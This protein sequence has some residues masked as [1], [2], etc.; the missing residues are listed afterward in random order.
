MPRL[1]VLA[2][3][4]SVAVGCD[5]APLETLPMRVEVVSPD[6]GVA[7]TAETVDLALRVR[8]AMAE[9]HVRVG[10][11]EAAFAEARGVFEATVAL[12]PGLNTL[13]V[14][15]ADGE[16]VVARDTLYA[17]RLDVRSV[18]ASGV[19]PLPL[20]SGAA[21]TLLPGPV[22][23]L[24]GGIGTGGPS[25]AL[26]R[27]G[28]GGIVESGL[29]GTARA[30]H[31]ASVLPSGEV[32]ILGGATALAP[33]TAAQFVSTAEVI[34][35]TV[36]RPVEIEGGGFLRTG[37]TARVLVTAGA[38]PR[39]LVYVYGG[40][41]AGA[42]LGVGEIGTV[43]ILEWLPPDR[44]VRLS[45]PIGAGGFPT[46]AFHAQF[47]FTGRP[48]RAV[49]V[50][51][52]GASRF[53]WR[54]PGTNYPFDMQRAPQPGLPTPRRAAAVAPVGAGL[55][56]VAGGRTASGDVSGAVEIYA[57]GIG[58]GFRL[59]PDGALA[60]PRAHARAAILSGRRI[61]IVGGVASSGALVSTTEV[62]TY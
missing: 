6:L 37:H 58:R 55:W 26:T 3:L 40:L 11:A 34:S 62:F 38:N 43:A 17:L 35:G 47:D 18:A 25:P 48:D 2:L 31:T 23:L 32:L 16:R 52:A 30:G 41:D 44:L 8:G 53:T 5:R 15:V 13:P 1:A 61:A 20:T 28:A 46:S 22:T 56:L 10:A 50:G 54:E 14:E 33:G 60:F 12:A 4:L 45:P 9:T 36:A 24:T 39:T 51:D 27:V 19:P 7:R 21:A 42:G 29:M 59:G 49:V 57:P